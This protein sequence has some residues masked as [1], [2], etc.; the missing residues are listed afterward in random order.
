M[1]NITMD[2]R[3]RVDMKTLLPFYHKAGGTLTRENLLSL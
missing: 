2:A 1:E 3:E